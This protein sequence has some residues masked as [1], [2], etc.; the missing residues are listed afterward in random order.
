V[1]SVPGFTAMSCKNQNVQAA[2]MPGAAAVPVI[3]AA[4]LGTKRESS[5]LQG[6]NEGQLN[7]CK[8]RDSSREI[9]PS[10]KTCK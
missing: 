8:P 5:K 1:V 4:N 10:S 7:A 3:A 2:S 6:R 9:T